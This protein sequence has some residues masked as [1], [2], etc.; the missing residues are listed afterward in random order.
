MIAA[1]L[2]EFCL[3]LFLTMEH[4]PDEAGSSSIGVSG[5]EQEVKDALYSQFVMISLGLIL[6]ITTLRSL[7]L[8]IDE[9]GAAIAPISKQARIISAI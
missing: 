7:S 1:I 5:K 4:P 9:I 2:S 6:S 8:Y 3:Y